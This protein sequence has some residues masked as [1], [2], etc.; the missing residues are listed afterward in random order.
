MAS[1]PR[2]C[3]ALYGACRTSLSS[4]LQRGWA[5]RR[6]VPRG[7]PSTVRRRRSG[8]QLRMHA[9]ID[10]TDERVRVSLV[11][12]VSLAR[13]RA[14]AR[15][16]PRARKFASSTSSR[17]LLSRFH[18]RSRFRSR[19]R[20]R[21]RSLRT[22]NPRSLRSVSPDR[23]WHF[24]PIEDLARSRRSRCLFNSTIGCLSANLPLFSLFPIKLSHDAFDRRLFLSFSIRLAELPHAP[25]ADDFLMAALPT[26]A[27]VASSLCSGDVG[28]E[29]GFVARRRPIGRRRRPPRRRVTW[30]E[31]CA[32]SLRVAA[33]AAASCVPRPASRAQNTG[34]LVCARQCLSNPT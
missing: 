9:R 7:F 31:R 30:L 18:F 4:T 26:T 21:S 23:F 33:T 17:L 6:S 11:S 32:R 3:V 34:R 25:T 28:A 5:N 14:R 27:E 29:G 19:S 24:G 2:C 16:L 12:L 13:A 1:P 10:F 20:S 15:A 8:A 22:D